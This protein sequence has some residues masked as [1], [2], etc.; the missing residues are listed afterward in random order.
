MVQRTLLNLIDR[1]FTAILAGLTLAVYALVMTGATASLVEAS[2]ACSSWPT[3]D[4]SLAGSFADTTIAVAI[5]HRLGTLIVGL[6]LLGVTVAAWVIDAPRAT[7]GALLG[8][9][10]LY[11]IQAGLGAVATV[12]TTPQTLVTLH[13]IVAMLIFTAVLLGFLRQ[14]EWETRNVVSSFD[15]DTYTRSDS[16][17]GGVAEQPPGWRRT[18]S[19]YLSLTKPR[20]M[21]L[22]C[23]VA[24]AG[25]G[26]AT[27]ASAG[28]LTWSIAL[29]TI[30]GGILAIGAS[31]TFNHV[32]ERDIDKKME[33]T[34]DRPIVNDIV[35]KSRALLFGIALAVLSLI[36][37]LAFV[38]VIAAALG[39][40]AILFYSVV[41]TLILKPHTTQNI[42]IGGAVGALP[43]LIG[44]A[45]VTESI[46]IPAL[47]LGAIIFLWT[48]AHF[49]NLALVYKQD[50]ERG[51]FPMLPI[52]R[53]E[54]V[55][56]RHIVYYLGATMI[57]VGLLGVSASL[58][59]IYAITAVAFAGLF[60]VAIT[61]LYTQQTPKA[62]M[63][64]FHTS[65]AFLGALMAAIVL[66]TI[67]LA[68]I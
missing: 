48:P 38:N 55:T 24:V 32:L 17:G 20:L 52:V 41:Y 5:L 50:Y 11:P 65:N 34:A 35:P 47:L 4:G 68:A 31:G 26:L 30:L 37:F 28:S 45:A 60:I 23:I 56:R 2:A 3:C 46:G 21:W 19:A 66:E 58:G 64:T 49:Y 44:W 27:A 62:A 59:W 15:R 57:G 40:I 51:G 63:R 8:A 61:H 18:A 54:R 14:L 12:T 36:V 16:D 1:R 9:V 22:L 13:L 10:A 53:G 39:L 42:V 33:R 67:V 6:F 25:M 43:A 7:F 29:G